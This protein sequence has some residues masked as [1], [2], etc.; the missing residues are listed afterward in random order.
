MQSPSSPTPPTTAPAHA[1]FIK[2]YVQR[3]WS[4]LAVGGHDGNPMRVAIFG[5]G[6]HTDWLID[7]VSNITPTPE[8]TAVLDNKPGLTI[9][10]KKTIKP[11][12]FNPSDADIILLS[13]D[14]V[15]TK[16]AEQCKNLYGD[17][18]KILNLY[19]GLPA[20]PYEKE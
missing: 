18:I 3:T 8:V 15:A 20:G 9:W 1:F 13:S 5:A 7:T 6:K 14:T 16:M 4:W 11:E 12:N 19:E 10:N 17:K 2:P